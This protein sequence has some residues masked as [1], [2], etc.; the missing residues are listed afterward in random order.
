VE[1]PEGEDER[2]EA[3][4]SKLEAV[5]K[6][7]SGYIARCPAHEDSTPSLEVGAGEKGIVFHCYAGCHIREIAAALEVTVPSLFYE[8]TKVEGKANRIDRRGMELEGI[9][10][11]ARLQAEPELLNTLRARRGWAKGALERLGVGWDGQRLTLPVKDEQDRMHDVIRYDPFGPPKW[12]MLAGKGR[13]RLPWPRPESIAP[14]VLYLVEGEGSVIS[15]MSIGLQAVAL[16]GS[17]SKPSGDVTRPA[18]FQGGGW[19]PAWARRFKHFPRIVCIPDC[20]IAGRNLM[21]TASY[22]L[23][24]AGCHVVTIDLGF[25]DGF[26]V[27]DFLKPAMD[28]TSRRHAKEL[29]LMM[30]RVGLTKAAQTPEA[31]ELLQAWYS[32]MTGGKEEE[33][34][35]DFDPSKTRKVTVDK[36]QPIAWA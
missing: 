2:L 8:G 6:K 14:G 9:M 35:E 29:L 34:A 10:A 17:V 25:Q 16:P 1:R 22:D 27:G 15:M 13:S 18:K 5:R 7:G 3:I 31:R 24:Q 19:H 26:D 21:V 28:G 4:L 12:K 33:V 11:S 32:W 30:D 36:D 20:D 23:S